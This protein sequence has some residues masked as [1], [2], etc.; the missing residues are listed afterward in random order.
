M[1]SARISALLAAALVLP[2][3]AFVNPNASGGTA[4]PPPDYGAAAAGCNVS[5]TQ[6]ADP[7]G[8]GVAQPRPGWISSEGLLV[9][10]GESSTIAVPS[11]PDS[12]EPPGTYPGDWVRGGIGA[13]IPWFRERGRPRA[14]GE[15]RVRSVRLPGRNIVARGDYTNHLGTN[16]R[17]VPGGMVFP[18]EGCWR[19]TG[20][21]GRATLRATIWVISLDE[22]PANRRQTG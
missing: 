15:L 20:K 7:D 6:V 13:K 5:E 17:V 10:F 18:R 11:P 14:R 3:V 12:P 1:G 2:A 19:V 8:G 21:S 16:S 9:T 22:R 4:P